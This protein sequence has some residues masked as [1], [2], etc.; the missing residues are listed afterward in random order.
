[1]VFIGKDQYNM[2]MDE[3]LKAC[4]AFLEKCDPAAL[5]NGRHNVTEEIFCNVM[6]YSTNETEGEVFET[7]RSYVDVQVLG[8][9]TERIALPAGK[10]EFQPYIAEKD[11][12][13]CTAEGRTYVTLVAGDLCVLLPG[14]PH[15]PGLAVGES[16]PVKK[17]V[18]KIPG[19]LI[20]GNLL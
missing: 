18:F 17:L 1:M 19:D 9:G 6:E 10:V 14:E 7:H 15:L 12:E 2:I 16:I 3:S 8:A 4:V 11:N 20:G 5:A 13:P